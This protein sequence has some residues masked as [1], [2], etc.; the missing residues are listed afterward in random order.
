MIRRLSFAALALLVAGC[1][2][3]GG[4]SPSLPA[5]A[6]SAPIKGNAAVTGTANAQVQITIP[7]AP[8]ATALRR[9]AYVSPATQSLSFQLATGQPIVVALTAGTPGCATTANGVVCTAN[10][11]LPVGANQQFIVNTYASANGSGTSLSAT[12]VTASVVSGQANSIA[13][14]LGGVPK[15]VT[16]VAQTTPISTVASTTI[17]VT[18]TVKDASGNTIIGSTPFSDAN[19]NAVTIV[20]AD[21]DTT[22]ATQLTPST[23]TAP[24]SASVAY[25]SYFQ[26]TTV[27]LT[28]TGSGVA[29]TTTTLTFAPKTIAFMYDYTDTLQAQFMA[30]ATATAKTTRRH[31]QVAISSVP[32]TLASLLP[33]GSA[34]TPYALGTNITTQAAQYKRSF[35]FNPLGSATAPSGHLYFTQEATQWGIFDAGVAPTLPLGSAVIAGSANQVLGTLALGPGGKMYAGIAGGFEQINPATGA[36]IGSPVLVPSQFIAGYYPNAI[37]VGAD[38]TVYIEAFE[39]TGTMSD[40]VLAFTPSANGFTFARSFWTGNCHH[41][42]DAI[43]GLAVDRNNVVYVSTDAN[44][45]IDLVPAA[46]SGNVLPS[47]TY[48]TYGTYYDG[49]NLVIDRNGNIIETAYSAM[50]VYAANTGSVPPGN[51][52]PTQPYLPAVTPVL[53][54]FSGVGGNAEFGNVAFG[55]GS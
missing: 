54:T 49:L 47:M 11:P 39:N 51:T 23:L 34:A 1:S 24:G 8:A 18:V 27:T 52:D 19:G 16:L 26:P 13:L 40:D 41:P 28:A 15:T 48:S 30:R 21:S 35:N 9:A 20:L 37:A 46:S 25:D 32:E 53:Q 14:T 17:P 6:S 7:A 44:G 12:K 33:T 10:V 45:T 42:D 43:Y 31:A 22:G 36:A 29:T 50:V 5:A 2:S 3:G 4:A 55:P 38:G